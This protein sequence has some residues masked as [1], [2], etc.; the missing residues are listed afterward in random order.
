MFVPQVPATHNQLEYC[1]AKLQVT[2]NHL[3]R[4]KVPRNAVKSVNNS[5]GC[6]AR[7]NSSY[8][9]LK[10]QWVARAAERK[11][12]CMMGKLLP[13]LDAGEAASDAGNVHKIS[14]CT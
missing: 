14:I 4:C 3:A 1:T 12:D 5:P 11:M 8:C 10:P 7:R 2:S 6:D 13:R 9:S